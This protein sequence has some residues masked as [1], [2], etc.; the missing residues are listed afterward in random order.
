MIVRCL[1]RLYEQDRAGLPGSSRPDSDR[2]IH[3]SCD[4]SIALEC[5][6][7][8]LLVMSPEHMQASTSLE[9]PDLSR[10]QQ[11][12]RRLIHVLTH[13]AG[14]IVASGNRLIARHVE[15]ANTARVS[16]ESMHQTPFLDVRN[17][18]SMISATGDRDGFAFAD[19]EA[20]NRR[21]VTFQHVEA[22]TMVGL[23]V[24]EL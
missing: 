19:F 9:V 16:S 6:T 24:I 5:H 2:R 15:T 22:C 1:V 4:N 21:S 3:R 14:L 20:S 10:I 13:S 12:H 18:E 17:A 8:Q 11:S 23:S 7:V